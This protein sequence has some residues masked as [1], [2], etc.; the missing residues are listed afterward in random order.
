M[1]CADVNIAC[2]HFLQLNNG[3]AK[4]TCGI[5]HVVVN[6]A[7][8]ALDVADDAHNC[9]LVVTRTALVSNCKATVKVVGK[10]FSCFCA[11]HIRG[12]NNGI[13]PVKWLA[14]K[15]IAQKVESG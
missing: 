14:L 8:L 5:N 2:T 4:R 12:D 6:N 7:G 11:T 9:A 1:S 10:L 3:C 13:L 15:V